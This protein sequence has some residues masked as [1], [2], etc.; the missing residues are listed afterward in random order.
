MKPGFDRLKMDAPPIQPIYLDRYSAACNSGTHHRSEAIADVSDNAELFRPKNV[1]MSSVFIGPDHFLSDQR[2]P[3][4]NDFCT[5][6]SRKFQQC[7]CSEY[8]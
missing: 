3:V 4:K 6:P 5:K 2:R 1:G 7:D 8:R